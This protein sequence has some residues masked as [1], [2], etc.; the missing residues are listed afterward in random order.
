M[1]MQTRIEAWKVWR[2]ECVDRRL[3]LRQD[4]GRSDTPDEKPC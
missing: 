2:K 4:A 1:H 3:S